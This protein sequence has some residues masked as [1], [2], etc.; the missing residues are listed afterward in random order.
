[1]ASFRC[2]DNS[3]VIA[4]LI[5]T[6][7]HLN[8]T[9]VA[10]FPN[11]Y[12]WRHSLYSI[13]VLTLKTN[14]IKPSSYASTAYVVVIRPSSL[15]N[16]FVKFGQPARFFWA[17]GLPPPPLRQNISRRPMIRSVRPGKLGE[18]EIGRTSKSFL[19]SVTAPII[20]DVCCPMGSPYSGGIVRR[21]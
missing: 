5:M 4:S 8:T 19:R 21:D 20:I 14:C 1:M 7:F 6:K 12:L 13:L 15:S 3:D 9:V 16:S 17:N 10:V 11:A 18:L 2:Y